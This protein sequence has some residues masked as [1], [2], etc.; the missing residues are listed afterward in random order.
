MCIRDS[1]GS[2][3]AK[4]ELR[5][6]DEDPWLCAEMSKDEGGSQCRDRG[7]G[8]HGDCNSAAGS[9]VCMF[10]CINISLRRACVESGLTKEERLIAADLK[11]AVHALF[12]EA[13]T[14]AELSAGSQVVL[15][16]LRDGALPEGPS[17]RR[18][19][20]V[21]SRGGAT[22]ARS[23]AGGLSLIHI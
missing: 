20:D 14:A 17:R 23:A 9:A 10:H 3:A 5:L 22:K 12:K 8:G 21:I 7:R 16:Q 1:L 4:T 11:D 2:V 18:K 19:C 13:E 15:D 6:S